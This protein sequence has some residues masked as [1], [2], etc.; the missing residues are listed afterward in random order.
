MMTSTLVS[1]VIALSLIVYMAVRQFQARSV[2][3]RALRVPGVAALI[4]A[5]LFL[6]SGPTFGAV[7]AIAMG[8][9]F[10]G[11]TGVIGGMF[12]RVWRGQDGVIYQQG[13]WR[14]LVTLLVF[15]AIRITARFALG[16]ILSA[17]VLDDAFVAAVLG[18]YLGRAGSVLLRAAPLAR[19]GLDALQ[20]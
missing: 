2:S 5:T 18:N 1:A 20:R 11:L 16:H 6:S 15:L 13:D 8:A 4:L 3:L 14:Y 17:T 10:G 9:L 19:Y 12:L 7:A